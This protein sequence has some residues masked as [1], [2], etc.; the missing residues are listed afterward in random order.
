ML[1][2]GDKMLE[3]ELP[4][5]NG[6]ITRLSDF[7]GRKIV[8]FAF[9]KASTPNCTRQAC[10]YRDTYDEFTEHNAVILGITSNPIN[11]LRKWRDYHNFPYD[12]LSDS[13]HAVLDQLGAWG[14]PII[15]GIAL[16]VTKRSYWV[17]DE[18]GIIRVARRDVDAKKSV[19]ESLA[20]IQKSS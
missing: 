4:N 16:P 3:F 11:A 8:L 6:K 7:Q 14:Q 2:V 17:I 19:H 20:F 9:P 15:A 10:T 1:T 5:Q 13:N 12:L 18:E